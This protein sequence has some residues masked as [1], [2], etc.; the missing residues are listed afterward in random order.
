MWH[1]KKKKI[2][3]SLQPQVSNRYGLLIPCLS[4]TWLPSPSEL[5]VSLP[6]PAHFIHPHQGAGSG[7]GRYRGGRNK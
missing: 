6:L 7:Y 2:I 5:V 1:K 3:A 4:L